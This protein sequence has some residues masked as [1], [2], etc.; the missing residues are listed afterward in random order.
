MWYSVWYIYMSLH[1]WRPS[2]GPIHRM[3]IRY[4]WIK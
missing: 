3:R 4:I 2:D 1:F